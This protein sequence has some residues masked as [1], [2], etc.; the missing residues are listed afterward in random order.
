G[1]VIAVV[2]YGRRHLNRGTRALGVARD[3]AF[4]LYVLHFAPLTA[5]TYLLLGTGLGVWA[6]WAIAVAASWATVALF[7]YVAGFIPYLREL[8]GIRP[9]RIWIRLRNSLS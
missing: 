9:R 7:T 2:G 3:L 4:P 1:L 6:R 5:A 8:F